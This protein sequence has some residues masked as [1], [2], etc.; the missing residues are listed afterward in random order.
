M[1]TTRTGSPTKPPFT[2]VLLLHDPVHNKDAA[3]TQA[4]R[5]ALGLRGLVPHSPLTIE[6]QVE[7]EMEHLR[8]KRD[9]L[10]KYIGLAALHDRN[11]TLF[12]RVLVDH[13]V[14]LLP[15][16][17]TPTVGRACQ[18]FSHILRRTRGIWMTPDDVDSMTD[19]LRNAAA[20]DV[21]LIVATD[22]ERILGLGD[23]GAG[24]MGIPIGKLALYSAAAGVHPSR[25]LPISIDVGTDNTELLADPYYMGYR[26]PR[27]RGESYWRVLDAFVDAVQVV[28]PNCLVQWED[29]HKDIAFKVLDRYRDVLPSFNDDIQGTAAVAFAGL[30]AA[31]RITGEKLPEQRI[32]YVGAGAAGVGIGRLVA[33]AM[34]EEMNAAQIRAAQIFCD[35]H[36]LVYE[37]RA[38]SDAHKRP[39]AMPHET[40][41]AQGFNSRNATDLVEVIRRIRPTVLIGTTAQPGVFTERVVREMS[42][43]VE[44]PVIFPLSNP[45]SKMECTPDHVLQWTEGRAIV[46]TGTACEPVEFGGRTHT[47]GQANNVYVFPGVGL[48]CIRS[49]ARA[50]Q[51]SVFLIAA[52]TLA[53]LVSQERLKTGAIYPDQSELRTVSA[54][55]AEAVVQEV[56]RQAGKEITAESAREMVRAAMWFPEYPRMI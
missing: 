36:G 30:L 31:L 38:I 24:G 6:Q 29:F 25:C 10:E 2:G 20:S 28:F 34:Q 51:N 56:N 3:F 12:F 53:S 35:S 41:A 21:Q 1:K 46:A 47:I 54:R 9:D 15:I 37:G 32:V 39:F 14:E 22:N 33:M 55:I 11:E 49:G 18:R 50:I 23:Q 13:L 42:R 16:V 17:Y 5:D 4:E 48:G 8:A 40:F 26:H 43:H 44:R 27:I 19:V 45:T 7:L 52:R